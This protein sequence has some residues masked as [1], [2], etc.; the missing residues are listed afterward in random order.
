MKEIKQIKSPIKNNEKITRRGVYKDLSISPIIFRLENDFNKKYFIL[1][2]SSLTKKN[3][4]IRN[5]YLFCVRID[6]TLDI[7][8]NKEILDD[9]KFNVGLTIYRNMKK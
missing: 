7:I 8:N 4:F 3:S 5:Y 2:F 1:R 6:K 9:L